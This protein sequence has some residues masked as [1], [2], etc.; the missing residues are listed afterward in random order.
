MIYFPCVS[1]RILWDLSMPP[2][3]MT[4]PIDELAINCLTYSI[5]LTSVFADELY[6][7]FTT[8]EM[9]VCSHCFNNPCDWQRYGNQL[10]LV[11]NRR[12]REGHTQPGARYACYEAHTHLVHGHLGT[13]NRR[14]LPWCVE[15]GI[16]DTYPSAS[17]TGYRPGKDN[18]IDS[19][20]IT[21]TS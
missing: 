9:P 4:T 5:T 13:G 12:I 21:I 8:N 17:Y 11:G 14:E 6:A 1:Y 20:L 15:G 7:R 18:G 3:L 16:K 19:I 10:L 2:T